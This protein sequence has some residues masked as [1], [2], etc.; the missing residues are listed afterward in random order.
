MDG[1]GSAAAS[2]CDDSHT[3]HSHLTA[4]H[5]AHGLVMALA[6][7]VFF[8]TGTFIARS[9]N[10]DKEAHMGKNSFNAHRACQLLGVALVIG[11]FCVA[12]TMVSGCHFWSSSQNLQVVSHGI[13]GFFIMALLIV[14]V[15]L[16]VTRPAKDSYVGRSRKPAACPLVVQPL[17]FPAALPVAHPVDGCFHPT[18]APSQLLLHRAIRQ[19]WASVHKLLGHGLGVGMMVNCVLGATKLVGEGL[20]W[21]VI[22]V[23]VGAA[24]WQL[25]FLVLQIKSSTVPPA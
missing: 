15:V 17:R 6:A 11:G 2:T 12:L 7:L 5:T 4:A 18:D 3:G 20:V 8:P 24:L 9:V 16:G 23:A 13:L 10:L 14:Q 1:H 22:V 25:A 21:P 19:R